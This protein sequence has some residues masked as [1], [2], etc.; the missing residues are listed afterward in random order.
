M[1]AWTMQTFAT[2]W[3]GPMSSVSGERQCCGRSYDARLSTVEL[4]AALAE[5]LGARCRTE[6]LI[7]RYMADLA[8][9]IRERGDGQLCVYVDEYHAAR[10]HFGLGV[11]NTRERVRVGRALRS[12]PQVEQAFIEG[13]LSYSRVREVTRIATAVTE[14][15][16]LELAQTLDMRSLERRVAAAQEQLP[17][18]LGLVAAG[19]APASTATSP[20]DARM[21]EPLRGQRSFGDSHGVLGATGCEL[22]ATG[23]ELGAVEYELGATGCELGATGCELGATGC[24]V[25]ATGCEVDA[26]RELRAGP[27]GP[28]GSAGERRL[29][30]ALPLEWAGS[31]VVRVTLELT[32]SAW[33]LCERAMEGARRCSATRLSDGEAL[34][35]VA[36]DALTAQ[37]QEANLRD[38]G[39]TIA[40]FESLSC[41]H[42]E[43]ETAAT[44]VEPAPA[45]S[46]ALGCADLARDLRNDGRRGRRGPLL[47]SH[48]STDPVTRSESQASSDVSWSSDG[49]TDRVTRSESQASND[50]TR[51]ERQAST[52]RVTRSE[53]QASTNRITRGESQAS[54]L[55]R[56][57]SQASN[58]TRS[59]SQTSNDLAPSVAD[60]SARDGGRGVTHIGFSAALRPRANQA[61]MTEKL[62]SNSS[63]ARS[64]GVP[65]VGVGYIEVR[66][67]A[68]RQGACDGTWHYPPA[69][70]LLAVMGR[71]GGWK[72]DELIEASGLLAQQVAA[73]LTCLEVSG[74]IR[75]RPRGFEPT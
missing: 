9:R 1:L 61:E 8:D 16:W 49:L 71:R 58:L 26:G 75:Y 10:C 23:C 6:Q 65:G 14:V 25:D 69:S 74:R 44:G 45:T 55:T 47:A 66:S 20:L 73:A 41:A 70:H 36:R 22:D 53:G 12:L 56:S 3:G 52:A 46:G 30:A 18:S 42:I 40:M 48:A 63:Q 59:E 60:E 29:D 4:I 35:A 7:C 13:A 50:L 15:V 68:T 31:K 57:E 32:A 51:S 39:R 37:S 33:A 2:D 27:G 38:P 72:E 19:E 5:L 43:L 67:E 24:E 11:R 62:A 21:A 17:A 64:P 28:V 34:E 54:N